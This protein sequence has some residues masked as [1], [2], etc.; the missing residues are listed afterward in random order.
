MILYFLFSVIL[1]ILIVRRLLQ[2]S[3][4]YR[5]FYENR[6]QN[7]WRRD[8]NY[9]TGPE[10]GYNPA[11]VSAYEVLGIPADATEDE[12]KTAYRKLAMRHHPDRVASQGQ[13]A[14]KKAEMEFRKINEA[15]ESIK[16][17]RGFS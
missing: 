2:Y 10:Y 14:Q 11:P 8:Y 4:H 1:P 7:T 6:N 12:V 9:R 5:Q 16:K 13:D 3:R 15:Y 17:Y